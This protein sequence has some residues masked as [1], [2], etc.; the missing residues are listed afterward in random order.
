M[1]TQADGDRLAIPPRTQLSVRTLI[2][3]LASLFPLRLRSLFALIGL[4]CYMNRILFFLPHAEV[5]RT[6]SVAPPRSL[7]L[8]VRAL[9]CVRARVVVRVRV[10]TRSKYAFAPHLQTRIRRERPIPY[11]EMTKETYLYDKRDLFV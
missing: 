1:C 2:R 6:H 9:M 3:G 4:F 8:S 5:T 11:A 10:C 7:C